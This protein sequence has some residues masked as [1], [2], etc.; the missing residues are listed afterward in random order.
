LQREERGNAFWLR[1]MR[2]ISLLLGRR[3]S[4][5]VLYGIALYFVL[6]VPKARQASRNYLGRVLLRRVTLFDLYRHILT[7][8]S[9]IHDRI[10]LLNDRYDLFDIRLSG[11]EALHEM[12]REQRGCLLFGAHLGSFEILRSIARGNGMLKLSVAMFPENA[13]H[14]NDM[15]AAIN[16]G[17][18]ADIIPLGQIDSMLILHRRLQ[19]GD[20]IGVL[21][22]RASGPD[23][24]L[25]TPFLGAPARFPSGPLRMAALLKQP[26]WFMAGLYRG[27]NRYDVQFELLEDFSGPPARRE[28]AVRSLL[29]KYAA[30]LERH[31]RAA[32]YNWFNFFD[33]WKIPNDETA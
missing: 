6:A 8:A 22:D 24:Y 21:A 14:I 1:L 25:S 10:Y 9:T 17:V 28:D 18:M 15:L 4:R 19:Q 11:A 7:F 20:M 23:S 31:C 33:F 12:H 3:L 26:V 2:R 32:P 29:E 27:G 13:R 5:L 16:P 30:A